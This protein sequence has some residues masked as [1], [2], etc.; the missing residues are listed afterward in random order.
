MM[1]LEFVGR[2]YRTFDCD[3]AQLKSFK[4]IVL[5]DDRDEY[6]ATQGLGCLPP[7]DQVIDETLKWLEEALSNLLALDVPTLEEADDTRFT[8]VELFCWG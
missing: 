7:L 1:L 4:T 8:K 3:H 5:I 6:P 2:G